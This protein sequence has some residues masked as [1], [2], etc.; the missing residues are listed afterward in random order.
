MLSAEFTKIITVNKRPEKAMK[1]IKVGSQ[2]QMDRKNVDTKPT[3]TPGY[4]SKSQ[5]KTELTW[6]TTSRQSD[7]ACFNPD[8]LVCWTSAIIDISL[9]INQKTEFLCQNSTVNNFSF[10]FL[11]FRVW[12][13]HKFWIESY[14]NEFVYTQIQ[15][16]FS[17]FCQWSHQ[18]FKNIW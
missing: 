15:P 12:Q 16:I 11:L 7:K 10:K 3:I 5:L 9:I 17:L 18:H 14:R 8:A 2:Y 13:L 1:E 4:H 6:R